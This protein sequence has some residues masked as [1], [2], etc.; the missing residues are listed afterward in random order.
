MKTE[1]KPAW[2]S[3][4]PASLFCVFLTTKKSQPRA[5]VAPPSERRASSG[6]L[7]YIYQTEGLVQRSLPGSYH[8]VPSRGEAAYV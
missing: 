2:Y 1:E 7:A 6:R 3:V 4:S 8:T 5:A